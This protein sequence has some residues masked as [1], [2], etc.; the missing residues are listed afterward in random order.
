KTF[1]TRLR[2]PVVSLAL[3]VGL[4]RLWLRAGLFV[5]HKDK[6]LAAKSTKF[7]PA[8]A[9]R[10]SC[11]RQLGDVRQAG[12]P[13]LTSV[14]N[15]KRRL[16]RRMVAGRVIFILFCQEDELPGTNQEGGVNA[17]RDYST[18]DRCGLWGGSAIAAA[19]FIG[20]ILVVGAADEGAIPQAVKVARTTAL[21]ACT[22]H[23]DAAADA[24][25]G[26][27]E[28]PHSTIA[29]AV[30]AAQAGAVICIAEGTYAEQIAAG[31]KNFTLAGGF[32]RGSGFKVRDSA[33]Y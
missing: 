5:G 18:T 24:G 10:R 13:P 28:K 6:D 21:P 32:Q 26:S 1:D 20:S 31:E 8:C 7:D 33:Q 2:C 15:W 12:R 17:D 14:T 3:Y 29:A 30:E 22:L 25:D 11:R 9:T 27:A 19:A 16:C 4:P 23:V